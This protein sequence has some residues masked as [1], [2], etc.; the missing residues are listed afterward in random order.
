MDRFFHLFHYRLL[1]TDLCVTCVFSMFCF[2]S[3]IRLASCEI[4]NLSVLAYTRTIK[5]HYTTTKIHNSLAPRLKPLGILVVALRKLFR[6]LATF[7]M[8]PVDAASVYLDQLRFGFLLLPP[9]L[10]RVRINLGDPFSRL[11]TLFSTLESYFPFVT[12]YPDSRA[13]ILI[14]FG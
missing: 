14:G 2:H 4:S 11:W 5:T 6:R 10:L 12:S 7:G 8:T 9:N 13:P 3:F 1:Y